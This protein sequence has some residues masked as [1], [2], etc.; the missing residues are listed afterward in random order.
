M[1]LP[2]LIAHQPPPATPSRKCAATS[3]R[4][5]EFEAAS[6]SVTH[7]DVVYRAGVARKWTL[8]TRAAPE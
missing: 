3:S 2:T 8:S 1:S 6:P 5:R 4:P 7:Q